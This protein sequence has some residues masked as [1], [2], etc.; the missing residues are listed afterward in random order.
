MIRSLLEVL[1]SRRFAVL[2]VAVLIL[3][4]ALACGL[5]V[6]GGDFPPVTPTPSQPT[7]TPVILNAPQSTPTPV[8][9]PSPTATATAPAEESTASDEGTA[10][11]EVEPQPTADLA[12]PDSVI[13]M[14]LVP[15]GVFVMGSGDG[16]EDERPSHEVELP[17]YYI[18]IYEVHNARF[19]DFVDATGYETSAE[20]AA[21]P[22]SWR[23]E[24]QANGDNAPVV[25]VSWEDAGAYCAW[26][27]KRLPTEAE[28]EKAARGTE[29]LRYPWG[30]EYDAALVNGKESGFRAPVAVGSYPESASPYGALDMAGNVREWTAD[31]G[32][33]PYPGNTLGSPYYG[34]EL[35]VLRGGGWFDAPDDLRS[36]RRN[37]TSPS[38]ANWDIG[39]RCVR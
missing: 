33:Y 29:G 39:F 23:D 35:R 20:L 34:D 26:M 31:P 12:A 38:A 9:L 24:W 8:P 4:S 10:A 27:D 25:R 17:D 22:K 37:P 11:V 15:A 6:P 2:A 19:A 21:S 5:D 30:N 14:V 3:V 7:P 28:W 36:A 18:D 16:A 32:Y 13:D 1:L